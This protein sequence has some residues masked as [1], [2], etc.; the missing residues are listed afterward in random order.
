MIALLGWFEAFSFF[1]S[2]FLTEWLVNFLPS[3]SNSVS[4]AIF[5]LKESYWHP[6]SVSCTTPRI[7]VFQL[8]RDK[9]GHCFAFLQVCG[10]DMFWRARLDSGDLQWQ[11]FF[12]EWRF[13]SF[14]DRLAGSLLCFFRMLYSVLWSSLFNVKYSTNFS[15]CSLATSTTKMKGEQIP[16]SIK[17]W[18]WIVFAQNSVFA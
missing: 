14:W 4:R 16:Q 17:E 1:S 10:Q 5:L 11:T 2:V 13:I 12:A 15:L 7:S 3:T 9:T 18:F 8:W 6:S